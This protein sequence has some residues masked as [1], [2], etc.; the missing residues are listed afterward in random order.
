MYKGDRIRVT[1]GDYA[2]HIGHIMEQP[3]DTKSK[4]RV[5]RLLDR[6]R[7]LLLE[8]GAMEPYPE[9]PKQVKL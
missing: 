5:V 6:P 4:W 8:T 7:W 3:L 1:D 2:G 9:E